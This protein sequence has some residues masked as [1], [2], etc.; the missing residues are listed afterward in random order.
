MRARLVG[1]GLA[2]PRG[3]I[4]QEDACEVAKWLRPWGTPE[5]TS[6]D[7]AVLQMLYRR[8]GVTK[9]HSVLLESQA[10]ES[11]RQSF[12]LPSSP[13]QPLGPSTARRME[14][15]EREASPLAEIAARQAMEDARVKPSE[16]DHLVTVSCTGFCAPGFDL[17]LLQT[18]GMRLSVGRTHIGFMGCHA[19]LNGLRVAEA[20]AMRSPGT[21]VLL[22][23]TELCSLHH[24]YTMHPEQMVA[25]ALFADGSAAAVIGVEGDGRQSG[26]A[27]VSHCTQRIEASEDWMSWRI[28]DHGF[29]MTL[30][31]KV[32]MAIAEGIG[33]WLEPWLRTNGYSVSQIA[34]WAVHPGGPKILQAAAEGLRL[35]ESHLEASRE[36]LSQYGNMSSPTLLFIM[37][38]W[39]RR[40]MDG[41]MVAIG[42]GPG[43]VAEATL[44][45]P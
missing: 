42:F 32:P 28:G 37:E 25:N 15:Y 31:P 44:F 43:L 22:C 5:M 33:G 10:G 39:A 41:P 8:S 24:Q 3:S 27:I 16:I 11:T 45:E 36:V 29:Q 1:V 21:N 17:Q 18:L 13:S 20:I 6:R 38:R 7:Q 12:Y 30:S 35:T 19:L 23:A 34:H 9:R 26:P 2:T 14:R 4:L 40:G